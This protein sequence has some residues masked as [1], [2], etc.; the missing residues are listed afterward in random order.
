VPAGLPAATNLVHLVSRTTI[1]NFGMIGLAIAAVFSTTLV[2]SGLPV[3]RDAPAEPVY[4]SKV[5]TFA[6]TATSVA[7]G[8]DLA[9][10]S[11][12]NPEVSLQPRRPH[13]SLPTD[14]CIGSC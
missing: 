2:V 10:I 4:A 6:A 9:A 8:C 7:A 12:S 1:V 5:T 3:G 11:T 13:S 14:A